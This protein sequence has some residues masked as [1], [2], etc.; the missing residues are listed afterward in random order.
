MIIWE[1]LG[2]TAAAT[3]F[4]TS[5]AA[6][7]LFDHIYGEHFYDRHKWPFAVSLMVSGAICWA[8]GLVLKRRT[9]QVVIDKA[10]G[11]EFTLN[12]SR[13]TLFFIPIHLVGL[14]CGVG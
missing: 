12:R 8:V 5:L 9:G 4:G 7:L 6:N 2:W 10:T 3:I 13:H 1:G 11:R 14:M